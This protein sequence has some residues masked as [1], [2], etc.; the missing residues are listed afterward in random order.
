MRD[1]TGTSST[2]MDLSQI[3]KRQHELD[4]KLYELANKHR[5]AYEQAAAEGEVY[6]M[7]DAY[8]DEDKPTDKKQDLLN[9]RY[10]E[11]KIVLNE[12]E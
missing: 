5:R 2:V 10:K 8:S 1:I 7:P 3:E 9:Q 11:E 4:R 12:Q 6:K